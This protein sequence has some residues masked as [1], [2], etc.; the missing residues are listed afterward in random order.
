MSRPV[1][2]LVRDARLV[3]TMDAERREVAGG[4]V[5]VREGRV[6]AVGAGG[7]EP[8]PCGRSM[9]AAAW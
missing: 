2:L 1:D 8:A 6:D 3:V 7:D 5:S 9:R 4:W